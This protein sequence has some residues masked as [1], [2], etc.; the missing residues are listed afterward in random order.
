MK[1]RIW[2]LALTAMVALPLAISAPGCSILLPVHS[3]SVRHRFP[4]GLRVPGEQMAR[5]VQGAQVVVVLARGD[6]IEARLEG[7]DAI[8]LKRY[9]APYETW[10]S[11]HAPEFPELGSRVTLE[12]PRKRV[13]AR[14]EGFGWPVTEAQACGCPIVCSDTEALRE[15]AG[16]GGLF[17]HPEDENGFAV[18]LLRLTDP[19]TRQSWSESSEVIAILVSRSVRRRSVSWAVSMRGQS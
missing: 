12:G 11:G 17:H 10:R 6:S 4:P 18:D 16:E 2:A 13:S 8:P 7:V 3:W 14:F 5:I 15:A 9:R 1:T 19:Q